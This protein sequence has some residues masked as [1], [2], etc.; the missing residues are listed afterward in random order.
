MD[1]LEQRVY[2][3]VKKKVSHIHGAVQWKNT[4]PTKKMYTHFNERKLYVV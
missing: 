1:S 4:G 2:K 3:V